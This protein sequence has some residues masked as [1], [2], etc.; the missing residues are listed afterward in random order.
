VRR[1]RGFTLIE[2]MVVLA[3]VAL[4]VSIVA[5]HY[6]G[7]VNRAEETSA[8]VVSTCTRRV[9]STRRPCPPSRV[10]ARPSA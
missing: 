10:P 1:A 8:R 5:P 4:L 2:L 3:I 7:R 9:R 6:A